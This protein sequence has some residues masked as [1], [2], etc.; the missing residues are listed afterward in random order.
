MKG[1]KK[2]EQGR[3][4]GKYQQVLQFPTSWWWV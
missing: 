1:A 2:E 4:I 3:I